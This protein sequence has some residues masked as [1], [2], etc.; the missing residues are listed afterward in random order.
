[1]TSVTMKTII[2]LIPDR[3]PV[4]RPIFTDNNNTTTHTSII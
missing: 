2:I 3:L 4:K 1:M